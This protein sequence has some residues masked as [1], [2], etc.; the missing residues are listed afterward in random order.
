MFPWLSVCKL[1][2]YLNYFKYYITLVFLSIQVSFL[3]QISSYFCLLLRLQRGS[4][5]VKG[6]LRV[7]LKLS[8]ETLIS[9]VSFLY[10]LILLIISCTWSLVWLKPICFHLHLVV[11]AILILVNTKIWAANWFSYHMLSHLYN[12]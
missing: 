9:L 12:K 4:F 7:N 5:W 6:N 11:R 2:A 1:A 8:V 3:H 10:F